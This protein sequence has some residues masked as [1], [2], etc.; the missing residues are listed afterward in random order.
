[1]V[2]PETVP[3]G[4]SPQVGRD[5]AEVV[6]RDEPWEGLAGKRVLVAGAG[7]ML[8]AY[9]VWTLLGLNE[10]RGLGVEVIGLVRSAARAARNLGREL[11]RPDFTL[12][13]HDVSE[14]LAL[15]GPLDVVIHGAS[16]ARPALHAADPVGTIRANLQGTFTLLDACV[17]KG[18]E[19]FALMSSAEVYGAQ[20][21]GV[22]L[23]GEDDYGR[24]DP[25]NPRASYSEGK[26]AAE[27]ICAAYHAQHGIH[28]TVARFGHIYGPGMSLDDGRVQADFARNVVRGEDILLNSDG[29]AMRTYTYVAD[30]VAGMFTAVLRGESTAYNVA[31]ASGMVAIRDLAELFTRTRPDRGLTVRFGPQVDPSAFSPSAR[32]GLSSARLEALGWRAV[33]TLADGLDRFVTHHEQ[34]LAT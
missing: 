30:A 18:A 4:P 34:V 22:E 21:E 7:G 33:V 5:I 29:S 6:A 23:I 32:Q 26:R 8:P 11:D 24:L 25:L 3:V 1:V 20:P 17:E 12:V 10:A 28:V 2:P 19:R 16:A 13:E 15:D 27:T 31:D 9:A 14:P